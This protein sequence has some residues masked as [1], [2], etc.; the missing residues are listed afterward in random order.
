[1]AQLHIDEL[2]KHGLSRSSCYS[3]ASRRRTLLQIGALLVFRGCGHAKWSFASEADN[4]SDSAGSYETSTA[5]QKS[6]YSRNEFSQLSEASENYD[7]FSG[8][9][10]F[11]LP[12]LRFCG[13]ASTASW[14]FISIN[15]G[16]CAFY[17][18]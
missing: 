12:F 13:T 18:S 5:L 9:Q 14:S 16:V 3:E 6:E 11:S 8:D 15:W 2:L 10:T 4:V 17:L 7:A 1:M